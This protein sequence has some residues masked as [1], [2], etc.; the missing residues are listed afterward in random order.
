[1]FIFNRPLQ[2]VAAALGVALLIVWLDSVCPPAELA[3]GAARTANATVLSLCG[4]GPLRY[5]ARRIVTFPFPAACRPP[6][7][8]VGFRV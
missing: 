2:A 1:M 5:L 6:R 8:R 7:L 4:A 3:S